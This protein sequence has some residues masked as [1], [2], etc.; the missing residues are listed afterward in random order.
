MPLVEVTL[1][2]GRPPEQLRDLITRLTDAVEDAV[3]APRQNIRVI[4]REVPA[5][6]WAAG[7]VTIE[8]KRNKNHGSHPT[9]H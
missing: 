5:T 3:D 4:L 2:E 6:H 9:P 7:D 8:E 1:V